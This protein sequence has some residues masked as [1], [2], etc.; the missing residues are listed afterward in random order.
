M[1]ICIYLILL[2]YKAFFSSMFESSPKNL[3]KYDFELKNIIAYVFLNY[4]YNIDF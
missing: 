4:N 2:S 1:L 3:V